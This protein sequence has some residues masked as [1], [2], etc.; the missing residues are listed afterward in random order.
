MQFIF[1]LARPLHSGQPKSA[2]SNVQ[3]EEGTLHYGQFKSAVSSVQ[4][5]GT[6]HSCLQGRSQVEVSHLARHATPG[7]TPH[8]TLDQT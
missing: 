8:L 6:L 3:R 7:L 4:R 2:V 1:G 5:E